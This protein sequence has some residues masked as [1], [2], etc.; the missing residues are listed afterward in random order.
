MRNRFL[1]VMFALVMTL[2]LVPTVAMAED[3]DPT[4]GF[5]G[6]DT[7]AEKNSTISDSVNVYGVDTLF[8]IDIYEN[9]K[10]RL[11][12]NENAGDTYT[13]TLTGSAIMADYRKGSVRPWD[14]YASK[15]TK[16]VVESSVTSVGS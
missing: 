3:A 11:D 4:S 14:D 16:L 8:S 6:G 10:W 12:K 1:A 15:I 13:L 7:T 2:M 5:C 9:V